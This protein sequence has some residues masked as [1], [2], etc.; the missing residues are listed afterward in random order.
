L[1]AQ[2][3]EPATW[4]PSAAAPCWRPPMS[5]SM[6]DSWLTP[7]CWAAP[8]RAARSWTV[9]GWL[10]KRCWRPAVRPGRTARSWCGCIPATLRC[11]GRS[12]SRWTRWR[13]RAS[14]TTSPPGSAPSPPPPLPWRPN[15]RC[16]M[17]RSRW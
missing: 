3:L 10:W 15:T 17:S 12:A 8:G 13:P 11:T 2:G 4:S 7:S 16:R 9:R 5:W 1:L 14:P 6:L